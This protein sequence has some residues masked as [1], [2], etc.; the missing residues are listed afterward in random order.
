[1]A[2]ARKYSVLVLVKHSDV[3][4]KQTPEDEI[5]SQHRI[6]DFIKSWHPKIIQTKGCHCCGLSEFDWF[7]IFELDEPSDWVAFREAYHR[8]FYGR[9]IQRIEILG[10]NHPEFIRATDDI[11]HYQAMRKQ[12]C[13]PGMAESRADE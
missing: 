8:Q 9:G 1:M 11:P 7:A 4:F 13:Y 5:K 10:A 6:N 3:H 12:D 2:E